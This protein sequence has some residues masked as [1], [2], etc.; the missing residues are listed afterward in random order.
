[1][2][3]RQLFALAMVVS[4]LGPVSAGGNEVRYYEKD[5][6]TYCESRRTIREQEPHFRSAD[7]SGNVRREGDTERVQR[8]TRTCWTPATE[9][10]WEPFWMGSWNP[11]VG[12]RLAYRCV[13]RTCWTARTEVVPVPHCRVPENTAVDSSVAARPVVGQ[14]VIT[15]V[16]VAGR[17]TA[18]AVVPLRT[19]GLSQRRTNG[20]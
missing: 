18:K 3:N 7:S 11:F 4:L 16:A 15:R 10:C 14:E 19:S 12:P 6:V 20:L 17:A 13:P 9:Y 1:M 5:G 8:M 2:I